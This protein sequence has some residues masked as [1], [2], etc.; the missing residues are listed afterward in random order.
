MPSGAEL[1]G[2]S[3]LDVRFIGFF[4]ELAVILLRCV[5]VLLYA[6]ALLCTTS[7][8]PKA[9]SVLVY[10]TAYVLIFLSLWN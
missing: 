6:S 8:A 3:S 1:K 5:F 4:S 7:N 10:P 9:F 2:Q